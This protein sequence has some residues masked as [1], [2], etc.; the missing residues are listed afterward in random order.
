MLYVYWFLCIF[1]YDF[2]EDDV[3]IVKFAQCIQIIHLGKFLYRIKKLRWWELLKNQ[4]Q[5]KRNASVWVES[6]VET[7]WCL[8]AALEIFPAFK[9]KDPDYFHERAHLKLYHQNRNCL[10]TSFHMSY[11]QLRR[12][13]VWAVVL[14]T[15]R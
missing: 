4:P 6:D 8:V 3:V 7:E 1:L 10:S 9:L 12:G 13:D 15:R 2:V 11:L 14:T 5:A